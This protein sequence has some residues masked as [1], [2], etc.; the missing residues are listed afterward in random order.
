M[1]EV[2]QLSEADLEAWL[3][4]RA[5]LHPDQTAESLSG[6]V[7]HLLAD[8]LEAGYGAFEDGAMIGFIEVSERPWGEGCETAP[9]GWI[10]NILVE[11]KKRRAGIGRLLIDAAANWS[12]ARGLRELGSDVHA[13]NTASLASHLAWGFG[14]TIR[15]VMFRIRL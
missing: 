8:P 15:L 2:R 3:A 10:E 12:R 9:V 13:D 4:L 11:A 1:V 7:A 5:A 6:E 14:E